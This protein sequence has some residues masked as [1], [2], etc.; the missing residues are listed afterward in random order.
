MHYLSWLL[1]GSLADDWTLVKRN[2]R[3]AGMDKRPTASDQ[4]AERVRTLRKQRRL[5]VAEL[6]GRCETAGMPH[7]TAQVLY[8]MEGQRDAPDRP[9]RPV[10]VDELL[11]L[12]SVLDVTPAELCRTWPPWGT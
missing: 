1:S 2:T 3:L 12:A 7:L 5:T 9:P 6:A 11:V 4:I 8:K 10:T